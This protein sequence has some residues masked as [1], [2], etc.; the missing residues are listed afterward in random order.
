MPSSISL[1]CRL[2]SGACA[3]CYGRAEQKGGNGV[4]SWW[5]SQ[6]WREKAFTMV[7]TFPGHNHWEGAEIR[8]LGHSGQ[9]CPQLPKVSLH[10]AEKLPL[11]VHALSISRLSC[12]RGGSV[13]DREGDL[14]PGS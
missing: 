9:S 4:R 7:A 6:D 2:K 8:G 13:G 11:Q 3:Q 5:G 10:R 14:R 1:V 12:G